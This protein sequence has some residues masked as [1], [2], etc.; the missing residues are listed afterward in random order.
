MIISC[1]PIITNHESHDTID[2]V[3]V[4]DMRI[5]QFS[6]YKYYYIKIGTTWKAV[7]N[8]VFWDTA[9]KDTIH[10]NE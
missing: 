7:S 1:N 9:I 2:T 5:N 6:K 4:T 3:T 10:G 8:N